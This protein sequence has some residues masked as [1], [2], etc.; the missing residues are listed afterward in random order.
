MTSHGPDTTISYKHDATASC[1]FGGGRRSFK[2]RT[3]WV[4]GANQGVTVPFP[5]YILAAR[6]FDFTR[7]SA[8]GLRVIPQGETVK[9]PGQSSFLHAPSS[10][11]VDVADLL[12]SSFHSL[13]AIAVGGLSSNGYSAAQFRLCGASD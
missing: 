12:S 13:F 9:E 6:R 2:S 3:R 7:P 1:T 8:R 10:P 5:N 11:I 4:A